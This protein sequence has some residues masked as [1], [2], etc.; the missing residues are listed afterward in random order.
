VKRTNRGVQRTLLDLE[1]LAVDDNEMIDLQR[2]T[3]Y[4]QTL[5]LQAQEKKIKSL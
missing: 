3:I 5:E 1:K 4:V 2:K